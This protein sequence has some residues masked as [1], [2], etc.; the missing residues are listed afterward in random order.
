M[1]PTVPLPLPAVADHQL[2]VPVIQGRGYTVHLEQA[3]PL[4]T[5]VHCDVPAGLWSLLTKRALQR[6]WAALQALH[7]GPFHALHTP[8]DRKHLKFLRLFGFS[9]AASYIDPDGR[10]QEIFRTDPIQA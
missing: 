3:T 8:G 9:K 7:G 4:H 6:D 5:F 1:T 10:P 2:K